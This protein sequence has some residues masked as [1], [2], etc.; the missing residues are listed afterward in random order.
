MTTSPS[1]DRHTPARAP[2][3]IDSDSAQRQRYKTRS[4]PTSALMRVIMSP[5]PSRHGTLDNDYDPPPTG[6]AMGIFSPQ[7]RR[8]QKQQNR[9]DDRA[10]EN[11]MENLVTSWQ[12]RLQ[13]ISVIT[14][15]FASMEA[16]MLVVTDPSKEME[17]GEVSYTLKA[18]N[19]GL[20][21]ALVMHVYAAVLSFLAAFLLIRY[22]LKEASKNEL[23]VQVGKIVKS[24][25][26]TGDKKLKGD[27]IEAQKYDEE[28]MQHNGTVLQNASVNGHGSILLNKHE[29]T[30][31]PADTTADSESV[32]RNG[33]ATVGPPLGPAPAGTETTRSDPGPQQP[34]APSEA[35]T[36]PSVEPPLFS[37]NPHLEQVGP[38]WLRGAVSQHLL[39]RIHLLCLI[40][41]SLGFVLALMG[42]LAYGWVRQPR[43]VSIFVSAILGAGILALV[44][45]FAPDV[46]LIKRE[47]ENRQ[48]EEYDDA[49]VWY[50]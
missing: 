44:S 43:E 1:S 5:D 30:P 37:R 2:L 47:R 8:T 48:N 13:L 3:R 10:Y 40:L 35:R 29:N 21:G 9:L 32:N 22:K 20:L 42:I 6:P 27:D 15:F 41:A 18:T 16:A 24:P 19:A 7:R 25:T 11:A 17:K 38:F 28:K 23:K 39:S 45:V 26:S 34:S 33:N 36:L 4:E 14:T 46:K 49:A 50:D 12:E 31:T